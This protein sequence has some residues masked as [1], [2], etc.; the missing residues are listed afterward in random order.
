M[1]NKSF[2]FKDLWVVCILGVSVLPLLR[3]KFLKRNC[4]HL[5]DKNYGRKL[6]HS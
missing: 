3:V 4:P 5:S 2:C 1:P 6:T